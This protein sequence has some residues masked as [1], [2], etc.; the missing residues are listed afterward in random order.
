MASAVHEVSDVRLLNRR[1]GKR[2][3]LRVEPEGA[4]FALCE[5][6][7]TKTQKIWGWLH[8]QAA[9][10]L[11]YFVRWTEGHPEAGADI[12]LI[13]GKWGEGAAP[14]DRTCVSLTLFLQDDRAPAFM[15]VDA[16]TE[17][18]GDGEVAAGGLKRNE[19]IGTPL[20]TPIF[21]ALDAIWLQDERMPF[22]QH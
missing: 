9:T 3:Q 13:I 4:D 16:R 14:A 12:N 6:C 18:F 19:V 20:A 22:R 10:Q 5:C 11:C 1:W 17:Y 7:G 15:V 8:T 2:E 21:A